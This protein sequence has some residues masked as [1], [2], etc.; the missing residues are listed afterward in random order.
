MVYNVSTNKSDSAPID[1]GYIAPENYMDFLRRCIDDKKL[2]PINPPK[3]IRIINWYEVKKLR[4]KDYHR[5]EPSDEKFISVDS[6]EF[7]A[8]TN[9]NCEIILVNLFNRELCT[10]SIL[11]LDF[12]LMTTGEIICLDKK[13]ILFTVYDDNHEDI[14][15]DYLGLNIDLFYEYISYKGFPRTCHMSFLDIS[16]MVCIDNSAP[17]T[18]KWLLEIHETDNNGEDDIMK[19]EPLI[20]DKYYYVYQVLNYP[21]SLFPVKLFQGCANTLLYSWLSANNLLHFK[22]IKHLIKNVHVLCSLT[23]VFLSDTSLEK[24]TNIEKINTGSSSFIIQYKLNVTVVPQL[25]QSNLYEKMMQDPLLS[26]K[27]KDFIRFISTNTEKCQFLNNERDKYPIY[28]IMSDL[29][30]SMME[31]CSPTN[32]VDYIKSFSIQKNIKSSLY[33]PLCLIHIKDHKKHLTY[34]PVITSLLTYGFTT[35]S[36]IK[37]GFITHFLEYLSK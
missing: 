37:D 7:T 21:L 28:E 36:L 22:L 10:P 2:K 31:N 34:V 11:G 8:L 24:T 33:I 9:C 17:D 25:F 4:Y 35:P 23:G 26:S 15:G 12:Y 5:W 30:S 32:S 16:D 1:T 6:S 19:I 29:Y 3:S 18:I 20:S 13:N 27:H 14:E